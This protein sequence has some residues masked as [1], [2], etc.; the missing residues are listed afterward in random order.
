VA[1]AFRRLQ[2]ASGYATTHTG[3]NAA[4]EFH[5]AA[6]SVDHEGAGRN[7][8]CTAGA[9]IQD[10]RASAAVEP[11]QADS[12]ETDLRAFTANT[13][14]ILG[15]LDAQHPTHPACARQPPVV[16]PGVAPSDPQGDRGGFPSQRGGEQMTHK[17]AV[18]W[19][20]KLQRRLGRFGTQRQFVAFDG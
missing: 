20:F 12:F 15:D 3:W 2:P 13:C 6:I 9:R 17:I 4:V 1:S 5:V 11:T 16:T 7:L 18:G 14:S 19:Q 10:V 8:R